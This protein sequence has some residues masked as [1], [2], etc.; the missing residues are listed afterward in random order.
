MK[1]ISTRVHIGKEETEILGMAF[2]GLLGRYNILP[3]F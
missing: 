1:K 2:M 3:E